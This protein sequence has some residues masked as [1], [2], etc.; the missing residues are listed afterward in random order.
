MIYQ[1]ISLFLL[2]IRIWEIKDKFH[3]RVKKNKNVEEKGKLYFRKLCGA[4]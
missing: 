2:L 3:Y 1:T 4:R